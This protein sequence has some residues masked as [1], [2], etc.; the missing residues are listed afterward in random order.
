[1]AKLNKLLKKSDEHSEQ[2]LNEIW[3]EEMKEEKEIE[4]IKYEI[5]YK[6][7]IQLALWSGQFLDMSV[8]DV[9]VGELVNYDRLKGTSFNWVQNE[10]EREKLQIIG[11]VAYFKMVNGFEKTLYMTKEQMENH[12]MKYSKTY[13]KNKSFYIAIFDEMA[14]RIIINILLRKYL[15]N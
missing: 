12:F 5:G 13:A 8:S 15:I 11:Y 14:Q 10:D 7:Y 3:E 1:M 2:I 9:R 4:K 6:N